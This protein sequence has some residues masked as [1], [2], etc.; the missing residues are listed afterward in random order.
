MGATGMDA[1]S[2]PPHP[3]SP[4]QRSP[5]WPRWRGRSRRCPC[6]PW[7][8]EVGSQQHFSVRWW[9]YKEPAGW[10]TTGQTFRVAG[11]IYIKD[12]KQRLS[13][14]TD[15]VQSVTTANVVVTRCSQ[16][17][18]RDVIGWTH[19]NLFGGRVFKQLW[20]AISCNLTLNSNIFVKGSRKGVRC[21]MS[22]LGKRAQPNKQ[23]VII[24][25]TLLF[26]NVFLT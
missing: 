26:I 13:I 5:R 9:W 3:V 11:T 24:I 6:S 15:N 23:N 22:S 2:P 1:P 17:V 7:R 19:P 25:Y 18:V 8:S 4:Q 21:S 20:M 10:V 16:N 14:T 12:N